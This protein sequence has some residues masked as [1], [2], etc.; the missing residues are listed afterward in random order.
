MG[1]LEG[2]PTMIK[3][4]LVGAEVARNPQMFPSQQGCF[5]RFNGQVIVP[6]W[7]A[8]QRWEGVLST[9]R[10]VPPVAT[11]L[12][13]SWCSGLWCCDGHLHPTTL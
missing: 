3:I 13:P 8:L 5:H 6:C 2:N 4:H 9:I 7:P 1:L 12:Q 10:R 11:V